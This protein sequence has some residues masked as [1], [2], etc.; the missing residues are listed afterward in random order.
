MSGPAGMV[1]GSGGGATAES[2]L[3]PL[4]LGI[5]VVAFTLTATIALSPGEDEIRSE[6][7]MMARIEQFRSDARIVTASR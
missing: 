2:F 3:L 7:E 4:I 5:S 1:M 6:A